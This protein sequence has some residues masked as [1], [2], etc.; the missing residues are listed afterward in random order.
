MPQWKH[1]KEFTSFN[2]YRTRFLDLVQTDL[3]RF[4]FFHGRCCHCGRRF[5]DFGRLQNNAVHIALPQQLHI[6]K[7][8]CG[9][10]GSSSLPHR[11]TK[12]S[13][14]SR[15][16]TTIRATSTR[17]RRLCNPWTTRSARGCYLCLRYEPSPMCPVRTPSL[18]AERVVFKTRAG[19]W[20][21]ARFQFS[22][23]YAT[24]AAMLQ[25]R[26]QSEVRIPNGDLRP[27]P[28]MAFRAASNSSRI[29]CRC[30]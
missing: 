4:S 10:K 3:R 5:S 8:R 21:A 2:R 13:G 16:C 15:S 12:A 9:G 27:A 25:C 6:P 19:Y 18:M 1:W 7:R 11:S 22:T 30:L 24:T 26:Y 29:A 23:F 14:S 28:V 17:N 20:Y